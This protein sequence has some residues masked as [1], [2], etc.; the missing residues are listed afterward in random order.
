MSTPRA[1]LA[2]AGGLIKHKLWVALGCR[3]TGASAWS[4]LVHDWTKFLPSEW[5]P[6]VAH[7][8]N[9]DGSK[10]RG[11]EESEGFQLA[12]LHHRRRNKHHWQY[13]VS[14]EDNGSIFP[15]DM[16]EKYVRE[17][18]A[19]WVGAGMSYAGNP[20]PREWYHANEYRMMMS[21][22]TRALVKRILSESFDVTSKSS[23]SSNAQPDDDDHKYIMKIKE[24]IMPN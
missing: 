14:V 23:K 21:K 9:D 24:Y 12:W 15:M 10:K 7:F 2:Y 3:M 6:Y 16:P 8:R 11:A 18:V 19:D 20:D 13:W 4:A 5:V 1:H 22:K 17:M